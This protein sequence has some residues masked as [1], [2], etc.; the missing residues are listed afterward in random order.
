[1]NII[2]LIK[3]HPDASNAEIASLYNAWPT[4][5][6]VTWLTPEGM[7]SRLGPEAGGRILAALE[8]AAASNPVLKWAVKRLETSTNGLNAGDPATR[9]VVRELAIHGV[10]IAE[11]AAALLSLATDTHGGDVTEQDVAEARAQIARDQ[12]L[13]AFKASAE[14]IYQQACEAA[15]AARTASIQAYEQLISEWD[16][17]GKTPEID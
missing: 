8:T 14:L 6:E 11:D 13:A 3:T 17:T 9:S 1:M 7:L 5:Y 16:G 2:N 15:Q 4:R 12:A 10:L